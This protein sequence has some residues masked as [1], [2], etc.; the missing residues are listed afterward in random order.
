MLLFQ[1]GGIRVTRGN[2]IFNLIR[3]PDATV[4]DLRKLLELVPAKLQDKENG[5]NPLDIA[6]NEE[7]V[8]LLTEKGLTKTNLI[9]DVF[10]KDL[11]KAIL[12]NLKKINQLKN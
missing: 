3:N 4:D 7:M 9:T 6:T 8:K 5:L 10:K 11:F 2:N 12:E 1:N